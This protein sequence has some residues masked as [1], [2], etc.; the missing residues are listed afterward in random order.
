MT[1]IKTKAQGIDANVRA[2]DVKALVKDT[3]NI[4]ETLAII[5]LL[6]ITGLLCDI[7]CLIRWVTRLSSVI[8]RCDICTAI[9]A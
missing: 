6:Q 4:Y 8:N 7:H 3:G 2:R 5:L 9:L 1:D